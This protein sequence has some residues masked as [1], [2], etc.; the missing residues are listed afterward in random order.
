MKKLIMT[1]MLVFTLSFVASTTVEAKTTTVTIKKA[2]TNTAKK[3]DKTLKKCKKLTLKVRGS[4]K[5]SK[6]LITSVNKKLQQ[7]NEYSVVMQC[8]YQKTKK[9]YSYYSVSKDN[10][11]LYTYTIKLL[12]DMYTREQE[13]TETFWNENRQVLKNDGKRGYFVTEAGWDTR[14]VVT[15]YKKQNGN[16]PF[17]KL[18]TCVQSGIIASSFDN[19][20]SKYITYNKKYKDSSGD[21]SNSQLI[22]KLLNGKMKGVCHDFTVCQMLIFSQINIENYYASSQNDNHAVV[23]VKVKNSKGKVMWVCFDYGYRG[24]LKEMRECRS[25]DWGIHASKKINKQALNSTWDAVSDWN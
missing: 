24:S 4:K 8:S 2:D 7:V 14:T 13:L 15:S 11:R 5:A 21:Y 23:A 22:S 12:K 6:K 10:A 19:N 16:K 1:L 17:Y 9:G 18:S 3:L 25:S 20:E